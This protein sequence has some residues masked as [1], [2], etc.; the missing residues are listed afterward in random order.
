MARRPSHGGRGLGWSFRRGHDC[1]AEAPSRAE[2]FVLSPERRWAG[3]GHSR[4]SVSTP[5]TVLAS[6]RLPLESQLLPPSLPRFV[7]SASKGWVRPPAR[8]VCGPPGT[9]LTAVP[10]RGRRSPAPGSA[11]PPAVSGPPLCLAR[12]RGAPA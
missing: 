3:S 6:L 12:G 2:A 10:W 5:E 4:A 9:Q 1:G 7:R 8:P 11:R